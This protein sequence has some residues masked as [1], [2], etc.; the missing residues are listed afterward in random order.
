[1]KWRGLE[2][3]NMGDIMNAVCG[4]AMRGDKSEADEFIAEYLKET[5]HA[6]ENIGYG[7]GYYDKEMFYKIIQLFDVAHPVFGKTLPG[8][9]EAFKMGMEIGKARN[10]KGL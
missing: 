8:P 9:K 4:I 1:M 2:L 5:L 7:A 6:R 10:G 3:V